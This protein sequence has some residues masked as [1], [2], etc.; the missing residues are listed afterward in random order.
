MTT[1]PAIEPLRFAYW[2]PNVS[3]GLVTS[4]IEQRTDWSF[5]YN[6][7]LARLAER[8]GFDYALS[9]VR[10]TADST[11]EDLVQYNDG[12]RTGLIGTPEQVA[13]R[14]VEYRTLGVDLILAGFRHYHE[15]IERFGRDVLPIVREL[16]VTAGLDRAAV[17][18]PLAGL[19]ERDPALSVAG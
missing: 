12:F 3:G 1:D 2:V 5:A 17:P 16:E 13:R 6:R 7:T 14:I 10:Y 19:S 4:T 8:A 18:D 11:F 9:Q 15:E